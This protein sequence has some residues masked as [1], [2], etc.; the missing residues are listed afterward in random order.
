MG[1]VEILPMKYRIGQGYHGDTG[2]VIATDSKVRKG[3]VK[4]TLKKRP[5]DLARL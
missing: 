2:E 1:D 3:E 4:L 5:T